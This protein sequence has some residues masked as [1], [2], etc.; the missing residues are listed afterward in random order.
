MTANRG[1]W[2][3]V[4]REVAKT[5]GG[6]RVPVPGRA[7]GSEPDIEHSLF[8]IEV[9]T[10]KTIDARTKKAFAQADAARDYCKKKTGK[11]KISLVVEH[12]DR[13][14]YGDSVVK[15][16]LK[17]FAELVETGLGLAPTA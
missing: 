6:E 13:T 14:D 15:I 17:D 9:K 16:R 10:V 7:R 2:K 5:L 1:S 8:A 4:E 12:Q 3:R 11:S